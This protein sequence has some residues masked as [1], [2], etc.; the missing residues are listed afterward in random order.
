MMKTWFGRTAALCL[1]VLA[2]LAATS[3]TFAASASLSDGAAST[4]HGA[5]IAPD[6]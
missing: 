3:T 1:L 2:S 4:D 5:A 6:G